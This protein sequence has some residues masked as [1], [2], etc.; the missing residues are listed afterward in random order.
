VTERLSV[1]Q[2]RK[3]IEGSDDLTDEQV[4]RMRDMVY[5]MADVVADAFLDLGEI[6]PSL[7]DPPGTIT[8]QLERIQI[9]GLQRMGVEGF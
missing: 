3:L 6:D 9:E 7:F 2:C 5:T 8:Q 1:A 4:L